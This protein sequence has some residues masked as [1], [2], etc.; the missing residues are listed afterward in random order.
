VSARWGGDQP[1]PSVIELTRNGVMT[2]LGVLA[3]LVFALIAGALL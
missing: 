3:V 1:Q 2:A